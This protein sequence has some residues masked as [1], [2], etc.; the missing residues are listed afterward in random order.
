MLEP[1]HN[2][3]RTR[4]TV[5]YTHFYAGNANTIQSVRK[6]FNIRTEAAQYTA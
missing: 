1:L 2:F 5:F 3:I 4:L 6:I